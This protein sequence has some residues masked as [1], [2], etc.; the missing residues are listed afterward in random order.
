MMR[1]EGE[2]R[3]TKYDFGTNCTQRVM[4][5]EGR[6]HPM[7]ESCNQ[8]EYDG[9]LTPPEYDLTKVRVPMALFEGAL[10]VLATS[11]DVA[12]LKRVLPKGVVVFEKLYPTYNHVDFVFARS[13]VHKADLVDVLLRY[14]P[15][16]YV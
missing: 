2:P 13:A 1:R 5:L 8:H 11:A 7:Y 12:R 15:M 9:A 4:A 14:A 6:A 3:L 16:S 10:D